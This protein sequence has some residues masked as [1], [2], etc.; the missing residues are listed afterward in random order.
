MKKKSYV[1]VVVHQV[2]H[3][4][5]DLCIFLKKAESNLVLYGI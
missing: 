5:K 1:N 2:G 4:P 3:L